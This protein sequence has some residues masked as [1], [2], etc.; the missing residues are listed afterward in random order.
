MKHSSIAAALF[1][2]LLFAS[3][4]FAD[5]PKAQ[6]ERSLSARHAVATVAELERLAG[7]DDQLVAILL[8]LKDHSSLPF[9]SVRATRMLVTLSDRSDVQAALLDDMNAND[10]AGLARVITLHL[11]K[12]PTSTARM[13]LG[14]AAMARSRRDTSF[15]VYSQELQRSSDASV[16]RLA[17]SG[18]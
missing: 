15:R 12:A 3:S 7:G 2:C 6:I 1:A 10:R 4:A 5:S 17:G 9:V 11:D 13:A 8:D 18:E 16:R 14:R